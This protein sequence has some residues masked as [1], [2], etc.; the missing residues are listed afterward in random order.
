MARRRVQGEVELRR[1]LR[2]L[3]DAVKAEIR[4]AIEEAAKRVY[5]DSRAGLPEPGSHRFATG[6]LARTW[7]YEIDKD[8]LKARIGT[9][10]TRRQ[11]VPYGH[12]IEFGVSAHPV[13]VDK[14][15]PGKGTIQHPGHPPRPFLYPAFQKNRNAN[16]ELMREAVRRA[17]A[18]VKG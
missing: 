4:P 8:G 17:I 6:R 14:N 9:F 10:G 7:R 2:G 18:R 5:E 16:I 1:F 3:P 12:F 13:P 11:R 15:D